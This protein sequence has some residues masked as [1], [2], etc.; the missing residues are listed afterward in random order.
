[1]NVGSL[2][3]GIGGIE[4]GFEREGFKTIWFVEKDL[5]CQAVLRKHWSNTPIYEDVKKTNFKELERPDILTGGFP[6]QD[7]SIA[8]KGKGIEGERSG[9]W[10]EFF[11]AICEIRPK[12]AI[13]ENVSALT[14]R[15]LLTVLGD[16]A[17]IRYDAEWID[18]RASDF[19]ALHKRE[20]IFIV[21][22]PSS[23]RRNNRSNNGKTRQVLQTK[24]RKVEE[25]K[26]EGSRRQLWLDESFEIDFTNS[27]SKRCGRR[28]YEK[29]SQ[30]KNDAKV[31]RRSLQAYPSDNRSKRVQRFREE[32]LSGKQGFSWCQNVRR[33]EDLQGRQDIPEPLIRG[34]RNGIPFRVDRTKAIGNAVV[35]QVAQFIA[36]QIKEIEEKKA[37]KEYA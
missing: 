27:N 24:K 30:K 31:Q 33:I 5:Y 4:L 20:R 36:R 22:Y 16:L 37:E 35:P 32:S 18:L 9:L 7:I 8:G 23:N 29:S 25:D 1:V 28:S 3:S 14:Y 26:Q 12:Y 2:F 15:G 19:G 21:A 17:K 10:K 11:R 6:C 13:V 34:G